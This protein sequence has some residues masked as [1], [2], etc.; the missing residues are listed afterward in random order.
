M[1]LFSWAICILAVATA[2]YAQDSDSSDDSSSEVAYEAPTELG[3]ETTYMPQVCTS[4]AGT[5]DAIK[6]H[7]VR[8]IQLIRLDY[9]NISIDWK[10]AYNRG[11]IRL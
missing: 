9:C 11:K 1:K 2:A 6:V 7:Y 3:I 5:G 8:F 10:I 4:K